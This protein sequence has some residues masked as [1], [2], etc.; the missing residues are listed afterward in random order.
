MTGLSWKQLSIIFN[1]SEQSLRNY[2]R[3]GSIPSRYIAE[4]VVKATGGV[5]KIE[6]LLKGSDE[7]RGV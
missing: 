1:I 6:D 5:I 2:I 7:A 3:H 4:K